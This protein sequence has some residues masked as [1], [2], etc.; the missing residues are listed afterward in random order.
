[1]SKFGRRVPSNSQSQH[2][3]SVIPSANIQRS[4]FNRSSGYKTSF[5]AGYLIPVFLDE[6]LPGDTFHLKT[7]ILAR[8]STPVVP[9]MDNLRLDIQYFSVPYRL[10][11][12]HWQQFNGEQKNPGDSTD[13]LIPQIK[14]PSGGFLVGS[15]ADYF[16]VPTGVEGISVSALPFR[17]YNLIYNEWYRDENLVNS[18]PLPLGDE[19]ETGLAN[20]PLRK[21][22]KRHD[23]FTSALPWPQKG[24]G[25]EISLGQPPAYELS[26]PSYGDGLP[27]RFVNLGD[28]D[29]PF[30]S[31]LNWTRRKVPGVSPA[32]YTS[33]LNVDYP[34][35]PDTSETY[36]AAGFDSSR[37]PVSLNKSGGEVVDNLT[38]NSLR[39]AF[40]LQRLL[41][42]DARGGTRYIEI[43][44]S[45]FGVISPDARV[46][47]PEYLGS[48]TFDINVNPVLQ[49]SATTDTT[50]QG[51]LAAYGVAGGVNRGFS[52]S[53]VEH[54]FVIGLVSVRADLTYQQ[55]IPRMFSRLTR[56]DFYWPALAHL[57][58]QA[59]LNKEIYAQ[60]SDKDDE[61]FGYQERYAEYRYRPSQITGKLRSTDP[62]SLDVWHLSQR[63]DSLPALNQEFIEE[64]PPMSR[65]LAVQDEPQFIM[66][67]FFDLKCVRPM[68]VYSVPGLIDHF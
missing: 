13:Y 63:F 35:P 37:P 17:A 60:G 47:R 15:L 26:F 44:R 58:E 67:A 32:Q 18:A 21:R 24:E 25:V 51:N 45:H 4:V 16:G 34:G 48:G 33:G 3:F 19:E 2:N 6:A 46:Q 30:N 12:D 14:A 41:E 53:F 40:Q 43:I 55:G 59:I 8:L 66:D 22:A 65:V 11:W 61:V 52:H 20:F 7:S 57:G 39:Q 36:V 62:Q 49:N 29:N 50:P 68:P 1:M 42:R 28:S 54:C 31:S 9:F 10:V 56:F 23:Y 5:D 38:I 27:F 64:N